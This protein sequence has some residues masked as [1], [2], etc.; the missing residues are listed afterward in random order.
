MLSAVAVVPGSP[1]LVPALTGPDT[2]GPAADLD[3]PRVAARGVVGR[4]ASAAPRRWVALCAA[5]VHDPVPLPA[6]GI[7]HGDLP[8]DGTCRGFGVDLRVRLQPGVFPPDVDDLMPTTL[9]A[10][11][12]LRGEVA[13]AVAVDPVVVAP[14]LDVAGVATAAGLVA[15]LVTADAAPT[16]LL[17]VAD[18]STG[19]TPKAPGGLIEGADAVQSGID[20]AIARADLDA[21]AGLDVDD[22]ARARVDGRAVLQVA[23]AAVRTAGVHALQAESLWCG[24]PLGVGGHVAWWQPGSVGG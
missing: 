14:T 15:S 13:P 21:L 20:A 10:A 3:A 12:W 22:C 18:G 16:G 9:L 19:L 11:A 4:L 8:V 24:A 6:T 1:A 23:A 17:V 2:T 5:D 7:R